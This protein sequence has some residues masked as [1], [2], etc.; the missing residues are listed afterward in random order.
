MVVFIFH[1]VVVIEVSGKPRQRILLKKAF[2]KIGC[3][4]HYDRNNFS[5]LYGLCEECARNYNQM[6]LKGLCEAKCFRTKI[7]MSCVDFLW[8]TLQ[9]SELLDIVTEL[10]G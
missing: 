3:R 2:L 7:F 8:H 9:L 4:G 6:N 5:L 1:I 10:S